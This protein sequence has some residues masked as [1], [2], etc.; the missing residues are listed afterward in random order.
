MQEELLRSERMAALGSLVAGVAHELNTPLGTCLTA[1][2]TLQERTLEL[3]NSLQQQQLRRSAL[4][5][6]AKDASMVCDLLLRGLGNATELVAH[7]KQL[8]VDQTSDQRR[9]FQ[10]ATVVSD[11]LTVMRPQLKQ[12]RM[13][14]ATAIEVPTTIDAYPGELGR[15]LTNLIQNAQLH[16]FAAEQQGLLHIEGRELDGEHFELRVRDDGRGM[17]AEERRRAFDP[18]F[19]TKLGQGGTGLGLHIS[20]TL[21]TT[22]LGGQITAHSQPGQGAR[23]ELR[24]PRVAPLQ[25]E[26]A[27]PANE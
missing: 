3:Q 4:E 24:L 23:F 18:F 6:Y 17:G 8:S 15:L 25:G 13:R 11:V 14:V 7:F 20:H 22:V 27:S 2:S 10:L 19:T 26:G 16:A 5:A 9:P 12:G 21:A 1:T